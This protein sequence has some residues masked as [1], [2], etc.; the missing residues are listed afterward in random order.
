MASTMALVSVSPRQ[1]V[2]PFAGTLAGSA[3]SSQ[4]ML[5]KSSFFAGDACLTSAT[6][7]RAPV[8]VV[9]KIAGRQIKAAASTGP[10][11][12]S[13]S[14]RRG[15][16]VFTLDDWKV[17]PSCSPAHG[18]LPSIADLIKGNATQ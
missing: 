6:Q 4:L 18:H 17:R 3:K 5:S 13:P 11:E 9:K 12:V 8:A 7:N 16:T 15:G 1:S 14:A 2:S 10:V